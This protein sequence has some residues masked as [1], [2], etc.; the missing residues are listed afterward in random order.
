M[1]LSQNS[2]QISNLGS[3]SIE[4]GPKTKEMEIFIKNRFFQKKSNFSYI[5]NIADSESGAGFWK[6]LA[7]RRKKI[8]RIWIFTSTLFS[9]DGKSGIA[10]LSQ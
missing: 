1:F 9:P 8:I 2:M 7:K 5:K 10:L 3:E 6:F 4:T